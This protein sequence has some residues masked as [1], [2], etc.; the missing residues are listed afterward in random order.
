MTEQPVD[1]N[2]AARYAKIIAWS[3]EDQCFIDSCP[4]LGYGV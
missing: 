2:Q 3:E 1:M 4:G